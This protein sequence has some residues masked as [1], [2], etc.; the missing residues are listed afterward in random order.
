MLLHVRLPYSAFWRLRQPGFWGLSRTSVESGGL[1]AG[2]GV[3]LCSTQ[4]RL[5]I[6]IS[7]LVRQMKQGPFM[8]HLLQFCNEGKVRVTSSFWMKF[9]SPLSFAYMKAVLNT[10]AWFGMMRWHQ[11]AHSYIA[12]WFFQWKIQPS[13][14]LSAQWHSPSNSVCCPESLHSYTPPTVFHQWL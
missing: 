6:P 9:T 10:T 13:S 3:P 7:S 11:T 5:S 2:A 1:N 12:E 4:L 8:S 14:G